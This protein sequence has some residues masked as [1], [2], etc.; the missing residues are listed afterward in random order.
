MMTIFS[1]PMFFNI[2]SMTFKYLIFSVQS[3]Y[4]HTRARGEEIS[5]TITKL[6]KAWNQEW[7]TTDSH[8]YLPLSR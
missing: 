7:F 3:L 1:Q 2:F 5:G 8:A 4:F 6:G